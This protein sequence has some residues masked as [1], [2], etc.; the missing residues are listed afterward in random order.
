MPQNLIV[1]TSDSQ[2]Q[3]VQDSEDSIS[4]F[5]T[6]QGS[7]FPLLHSH[8]CPSA[9]H[10]HLSSSRVSQ[11]H[12]HQH[13]PHLHLHHYHCH[14]HPHPPSHLTRATNPQDHHFQHPRRRGPGCCAPGRTWRLR[15][16]Q[17]LGMGSGDRCGGRRPGRLG[18]GMRRVVRG[19][20]FL[21]RI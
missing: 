5:P 2:F 10:P 8:H 19:G 1:S 6:P 18:V 11:Q 15:T 17:R 9:A 16:A 12:Y 3:A 14:Y 20:P 7:N 21:V 13:S 4:A